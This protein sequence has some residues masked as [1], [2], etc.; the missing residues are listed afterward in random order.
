MVFFLVADSKNIKP[1]FIIYLIL[2]IF[3]NFFYRLF[4]EKEVVKLK[5][6]FH[7]GAAHKIGLIIILPLTISQFS[8]ESKKIMSRTPCLT[9]I[10]AVIKKVKHIS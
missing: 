1:F 9:D 6:N 4:L 10:E 5:Y 8:M 7:E 3:Y 2:M